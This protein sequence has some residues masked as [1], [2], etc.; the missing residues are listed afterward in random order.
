LRLTEPAFLEIYCLFLLFARS[1][2]PVGRVDFALEPSRGLISE[3]AFGPLTLAACRCPERKR[4]PAESCLRIIQNLP[5]LKGRG[6][7]HAAA[8]DSE[9]SGL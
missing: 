2:L 9:F 4:S 8:Q 5:A 3:N 7:S 1:P 6:I